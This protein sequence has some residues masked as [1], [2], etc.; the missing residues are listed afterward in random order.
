MK[1]GH[2]IGMDVHCQFCEIEVLNARGKL[3]QRTRCE[4]TI[5]TLAD[6][7]EKVPQPRSLVIEE[8][9]GAG[10]G[11]VLSSPWPETF[12]LY[13][14]YQ[15]ALMAMFAAAGND[16]TWAVRVHEGM[17]EAGLA[18]VRTLVRARSWAVLFRVT[19]RRSPDG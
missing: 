15:Q 14:Q 16:P 18:E 7:I 10:P 5:S 12:D 1:R 2:F 6:V 8:W 19:V 17:L 9:G 4:T 13:Q 11:Q 3:V